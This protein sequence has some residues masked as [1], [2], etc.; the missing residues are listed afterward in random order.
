MSSRALSDLSCG[1]P[2]F[3]GEQLLLA[4]VCPRTDWL[5]APSSLAVVPDAATR[6]ALARAWLRDAQLEHASIASFARFSLQL[7]AFGAPAELIA[8]AHRAALDEVEHAQAC[9]AL[10]SR[11]AGRA[12]GPGQLPMPSSFAAISLA[13]TAATTMREGCIAETIAARLAYEQLQHASDET[14][15][16]AL[17]RI[18]TDETQHAGLAYQFVRW[19]ISTGGAEVHA[20][21]ERAF[22]S[23]REQL[24]AAEIKPQE[25]DVALG[26]WHAHGRLS[27]REQRV[28]ELS[29]LQEVIEP[30]AS[31][32]LDGS[33]GSSDARAPASAS[34]C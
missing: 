10:A 8:S 9:F 19:A 26:D 20:S 14:A 28:C 33:R 29:C 31:S 18:A 30:C 24:L 6:A 2:F 21:V 12:L 34:K 13:E 11:Y 16:A 7:L 5:E 32:L 15:Q 4:P 22:A 3:D 1:R 27:A 25:D 17:L 23:A